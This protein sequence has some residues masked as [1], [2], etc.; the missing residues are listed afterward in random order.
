MNARQ[1][2]KTPILHKNQILTDNN[3]I[4]KYA[5]ALDPTPIM[6]AH[7]IYDGLR[8][9]IVKDVDGTFTRYVYD[10]ED[11]ILELDGNNNQLAYYTHG[12]GIDEPISMQRAGQNY[13]F[14]TDALGSIIK[15]VDTSGNTVNE[16]VYDSFGNMVSKT[17][18]V[19]N[20][21]TYYVQ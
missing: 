7:Y 13:Y 8:R 21:Y 14:I 16:Y 2:I 9:R 17:E 1:K 11:I 12:Q 3:G 19:T 5:T 20:Y 10:N 6:S 4:D 15:V 18:G